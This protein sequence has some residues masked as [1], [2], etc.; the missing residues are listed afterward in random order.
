M[1]IFP[2]PDF[3]AS[4]SPCA[5]GIDIALI[6]CFILDYALHLYLA[7]NN[8]VAY[9]VS[10]QSIIALIA[11]LPILALFL[12]SAQVGFLR[13]L[14]NCAPFLDVKLIL[15]IILV[16]LL[17][18][19]RVL[20]VLRITRFTTEVSLHTFFACTIASVTWYISGGPFHESAAP[21]LHAGVTAHQT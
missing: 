2:F 20:R 17:R 13:P 3:S 16:R 19:I 18:G 8:R 15:M 4:H 10:T 9:I 12:P 1:V 5:I 7:R 14:H 21:V 6:V 11:I